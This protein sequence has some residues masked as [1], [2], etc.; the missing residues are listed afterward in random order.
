MI[1]QR[2]D[3]FCP[4]KSIDHKLNKLG[5]T[6]SSMIANNSSHDNLPASTS[7]NSLADDIRVYNTKGQELE[8][9]YLE[10]QD[11]DGSNDNDDGLI[12]D[13]GGAEDEKFHLDNENQTKSIQN[14]DH[15][16]DV[17]IK[18]DYEQ[19]LGN[20]NECSLSLLGACYDKMEEKDKHYDVDIEGRF[21]YE[22]D[23]LALK[24]NEDY[25]LLLRTLAILESQRAQAC[26]D[27][28][29]LIKIRKDALNDPVAFVKKLQMDKDLGMPR[30][31]AVLQIP[32]IKWDEYTKALSTLS[33]SENDRLLKRHSARSTPLK[34]HNL[35]PLIDASQ[36]ELSSNAYKELSSSDSSLLP[37]YMY[38][39]A[40]AIVR[41]R[42]YDETKP[43]S[44]NQ[45]WSPE[46][47]LRL[48][49]LLEVFP[50]EEIESRRWEKIANAL[51]NRT[52][53]Q[54]ASRVQKYF[55]RLAKLGLPIPGRVPNM[56]FYKKGT[57]KLTDNPANYQPF[58]RPSVYM[59]ENDKDISCSAD[60]KRS[61]STSETVSDDE[62][63]DFT[64]KNSDEYKQLIRLKKI[65]KMQTTVRKVQHHGY[66]C[67]RCGM[68]PILG[69]RFHCKD[70]PADDSVDFC[71]DCVI[72]PMEIRLHKLN[73][74]LQVFNRPFYVDDDYIGY[75]GGSGHVEQSTGYTT[76]YSYLD[77]NYIPND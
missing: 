46:E 28:C 73:H 50:S 13:V 42:I 45:L 54:V 62:E 47:Q 71:K 25:Q 21:F 10:S 37:R 61:L 31:Q 69:P 27:I 18:R 9:A 74:E 60:S 56:P 76:G 75:T 20:C 64:L 67:D 24:N 57:K 65:K 72:S 32:T 52:P 4:D 66:Q 33:Q 1:A 48:E 39:I 68:E 58:C 7:G 11:D 2:G 63:I 12:I 16:S 44:F 30:L 40:G 43:S 15:G 59:A 3:R 55:I 26:Q 53:K 6:D 70:C 29:E 5:D 77:P 34:D 38:P 51:G 22:S 19:L 41:G 23:H 36:P 8:L 17:G 49:K 14:Y 35:Q